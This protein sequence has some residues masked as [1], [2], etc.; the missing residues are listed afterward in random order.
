MQTHNC[1]CYCIV[2][3]IRAKEHKYF[4]NDL[5]IVIKYN[6]C[7]IIYHYHLT[8]L[9]CNKRVTKRNVLEKKF[10]FLY[11]YKFRFAA[12]APALHG[13]LI[14]LSICLS[15]NPRF[16]SGHIQV[17]IIYRGE[18]RT[19]RTRTF[20]PNICNPPTNF[21]YWNLLIF[22]FGHTRVTL[23]LQFVYLKCISNRR[24]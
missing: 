23:Q 13:R 8:A 15:K 24:R 12:S 4:A 19:V 21:S 2:V 16:F 22:C 20:R 3:N 18:R 10:F 5:L 9:F 14:H 11:L 6:Y 17:T 7:E 1:R